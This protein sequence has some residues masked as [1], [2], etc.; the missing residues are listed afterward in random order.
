MRSIVAE[1]ISLTQYNK[2]LQT[3][4][5]KLRPS[6]CPHC[7]KSGVWCHGCYTR[8]ADYKRCGAESLNPI[9]IMRFY[10]PS[11]HKTCSVLP[12]CIPPQRNYPWWIQEIVLQLWVNGVSYK[13]IS[14]QTKPSRR[15]I[16][17]W[18]R[19]LKSQFLIHADHLRTILPSLR[20]L[21]DPIPFWKSLL[22]EFRLSSIML[23]LNN[24]GVIIP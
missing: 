9:F 6:Q 7:N 8:K 2:I 12:E 10:C 20:R 15:T 4:V 11:C 1:I 18:C 3:E 5:E 24:A 22:Q 14:Q 21:T 16:S 19:R 13:K 23:N 17:R